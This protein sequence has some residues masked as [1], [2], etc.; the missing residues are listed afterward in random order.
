MTEYIGDGFV[1]D[2]VDELDS[3]GGLLDG[4]SVPSIPEYDGDYEVYETMPS[5]D[6]YE[7]DYYYYYD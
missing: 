6:Y 4:V 3:V 5:E 2:M 7:D 1:E